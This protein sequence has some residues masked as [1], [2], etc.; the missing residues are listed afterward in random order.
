MRPDVLTRTPARAVFVVLA[1]ALLVVACQAPADQ[2]G[3][4]A[5]GSATTLGL[6]VSY[7]ASPALTAPPPTEI[8]ASDAPV[9]PDVLTSADN[10]YEDPAEGPA[11][12][13]VDQLVMSSDLRQAWL[14]TDLLRFQS[15]PEAELL[16]EGLTQLTGQPVPPGTAAWVFYADLLLVWDVPAPPGYVE[17]KRNLFVAHDPSW[18]VFLEAESTDLDWRAVSWA[19]VDRDQIVALDDPEVVAVAESDW[20]PDDDIIFGVEIEGERR[21]YP[22]RVLEVHEVVND[23]VGGQP[24]VVSWCGQCG[25]ATAF[26]ATTAANGTLRFRTSGLLDW[27]NKLVYDIGTESLFDQFTGAAVTGEMNGDAVALAPI[28]VLTTTWGAWKAA[29]PDST[30]VS[31]DAGVGRVYV[32][33][34]LGEGEM[35]GAAFPAGAVDDRLDGARA[36]LGTWAPDGTPVAF[37]A[38]AAKAMLATGGVL[39]WRGVRVEEQAGGLSATDAVTGA[40]LVSYEARWLAWSH[41][42]PATEVWTG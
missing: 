30:V 10:L 14:L 29:H 26:E 24:L 42:R 3:D 2:A 22:K 6:P 12:P 17:R 20:L 31:S 8:P 37:D 23:A 39:E 32:A 16:T 35:V 1:M 33:D 27:S 11:A 34:P 25:A 28:S 36:V 41:F 5:G 15:G 21:A 19:G 7:E 38:G 40:P 18:R 9:D 13:D 4:T